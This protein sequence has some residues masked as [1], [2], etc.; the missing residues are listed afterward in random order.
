MYSKVSV[1]N[2]KLPKMI[3]EKNGD[4]KI[5][6]LHKI[7][8]RYLKIPFWLTSMGLLATEFSFSRMGTGICWL[9]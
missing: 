7:F 3:P 5:L 8:F 9:F 2:N 4:T 6:S 1:L